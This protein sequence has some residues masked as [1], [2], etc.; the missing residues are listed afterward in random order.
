MKRLLHLSLC[1]AACLLAGCVNLQ[2]ISD[3][4]ASARA[5][6]ADTT[7]AA[8][9][10]DS[11]KRLVA[12]GR[13]GDA[14][15]V[16]RTGRLP[17]ADFDAAFEQAA[18][19]HGVLGRYFKALGELASDKLPLPT[20]ATDTT[21]SAIK[22]AGVPVSAEHQAAV[23]ALSQLLSRSLDGYRQAQLRDLMNRTQADV[24]LSI[25]LLTRLAGVYADEVHGEGVQAANF[26]K[27]SMATG[28]ISDKFWGRREAQRVA[29]QYQAE[30]DGLRRYQQALDKV[31]QDHARIQ[32]ALSLDKAQ[33]LPTL[34][35]IADTAKELDAARAALAALS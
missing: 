6:L 10:R 28:D 18:Q 31:R 27:C 21:L 34:K 13:P 32:Q 3:Y 19:V 7:A 4:S 35:A 26:Y 30:L 5:V 25:Q 22:K 20:A 9:W 17:Q 15:P 16:G 1:L 23:S 11:E 33:W 12:W 24:D 14:C 8:R 2:A 29:A